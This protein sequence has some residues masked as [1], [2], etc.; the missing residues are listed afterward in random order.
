MTEPIYLWFQ[1]PG[2]NRPRIE[3]I[4]NRI[5]I[6]G[7]SAGDRFTVDMEDAQSF[8]FVNPSGKYA[9]V[10]KSKEGKEFVCSRD[11]KRGAG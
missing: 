10:K 6:G 1:E 4:R 2:R 8:Y 9:S 11:G 7:W 3:M 5:G